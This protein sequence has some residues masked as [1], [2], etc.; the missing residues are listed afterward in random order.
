MVEKRNPPPGI[1]KFI[2]HE[3]IVVPNRLKKAV[4]I[5]GA[6][7]PDPV[8]A[9]EEALEQLSVQFESWMSD[10]CEQ[11]DRARKRVHAEGYTD[12]ARQSLFRAA[13]DIKGHAA[14]FGFPTAA[15]VAE[16]LCRLIEETP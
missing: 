6:E 2:D 11:L 13:H 15:D 5:A 4:R 10:E 12:E 8:S 7:E 3:V 9:A 1:R 16:S 14:T